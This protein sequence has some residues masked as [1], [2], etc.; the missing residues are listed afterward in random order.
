MLEYQMNTWLLGPID[1]Y[2]KHIAEQE[3]LVWDAWPFALAQC[4]WGAVDDRPGTIA[5]SATNGLK[6]PSRHG[7]SGLI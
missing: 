5:T 4:R 1:V 7:I 2:R 6:C 3:N